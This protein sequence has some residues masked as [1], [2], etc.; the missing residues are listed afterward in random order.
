IYRA[1]SEAGPVKGVIVQLGGQTPLS[2]ARD[3]EA[4][5]VPILGTSPS[6]IDVA[7]DRE[8]FAKVLAIAGCPAPAHDTAHVVSQVREVA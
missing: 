5:G 2:L 1:E 6:S 3:L 7:E 4:A 8:E